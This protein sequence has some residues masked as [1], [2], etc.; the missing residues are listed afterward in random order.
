MKPPEFNNYS[1]STIRHIRKNPN[2]TQEEIQCKEQAACFARCLLMPEKSVKSIY[3]MIKDITPFRTKA[4]KDMAIIFGV[5][6]KEMRYRL[7]EL[8][9]FF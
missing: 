2:A 4:I 6:I 7:R 1:P 8:K 5:D 3:K 9:L